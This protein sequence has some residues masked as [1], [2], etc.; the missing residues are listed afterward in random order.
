MIRL[1]KPKI[2]KSGD[3]KFEEIL[4]LYEILASKLKPEN[5]ILDS[6]ENINYDIMDITD[7]NH[8][9]FGTPLIERDQCI[10]LK[11]DCN[12]PRKPPCKTFKSHCCLMIYFQSLFLLSSCRL[13]Q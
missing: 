12:E 13:L 5:D 2:Y 10:T 7:E 1:R 4:Q 11:E 8:P 9:C 3:E 6:D